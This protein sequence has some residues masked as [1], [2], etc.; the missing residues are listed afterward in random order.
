MEDHATGKIAKHN[1]AISKDDKEDGIWDL[2]KKLYTADFMENQTLPSNSV[3]E[4]LME[5]SAE[6]IKF[7]KLMDEGCTKSDGHY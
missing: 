2:V 6:D 5:V 3:N 1:F 7:L 4:K